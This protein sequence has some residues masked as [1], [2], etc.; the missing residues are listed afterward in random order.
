MANPD[1]TELATTTIRH[2][3]RRLADNITNNN[4]LLAHL[5]KRGNIKSFSGGRTIL[6]EIMYDEN[7]TF[8]WYSG[9]EVLDVRPNDIL[10][11]A[12]FGVKQCAATVMISGLEKIQNSGKEKMIDLLD[13]RIKGAERTMT[14]QLSRGVYSDGTG[15]NGKQIGG[16]ASLVTTAP[17]TGKVGGIDRASHEFWRNA[18]KVN[19][20]LSDIKIELQDMWVQMVRGDD[21][22]TAM[23]ADNVVY[24][25]FWNSLQDQQRYGAD[26]SRANMGFENLMFNNTPF[27]LDGGYQG[28]APEKRCYFINS[29]YLKLRYHPDMNMTSTDMTRQPNQDA[30]ASFIQW[31]GNMCMSN[32]FLQ[33]VI[34]FA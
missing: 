1:M 16:L 29:N 19:A 6:E 9:Y 3:S 34:Q 31:A 26:G 23:V 5:K 12:E 2:R 27:L 28:N 8:K 7:D 25:A 13:S 17:A 24:T 18:A 11:A 4:A 30:Y 15:N 21:Q 10:S 33:G 22:P 14:N 32:A 20:V